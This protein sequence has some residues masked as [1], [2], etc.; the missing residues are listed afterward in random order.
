MRLDPKALEA[1]QAV[2]GHTPPLSVAALER[3]RPIWI[4][5]YRATTEPEQTQELP[6]VA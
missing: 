1:A 2:W 4:P 3:I 6:D 5:A